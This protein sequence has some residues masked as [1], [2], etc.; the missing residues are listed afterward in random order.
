MVCKLH[1]SGAA[2][3]PMVILLF[4]ITSTNCLK[5]YPQPSHPKLVGDQLT[6]HGGCRCTLQLGKVRSLGLMNSFHT[7]KPTQTSGS[8][9][10]AVKNNAS[11][12]FPIDSLTCKT[13]KH[14]Y[15]QDLRKTVIHRYTKGNQINLNTSYYYRN[16]L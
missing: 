12:N 4:S 10:K 13:G 2:E 1:I 6:C 14:A 11:Y 7:K 5:C 9:D 15:L 3:I 8:I 16:A